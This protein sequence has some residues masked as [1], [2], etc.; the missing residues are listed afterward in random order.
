MT[1]SQSARFAILCFVVGLSPVPAVAVAGFAIA[2]FGFAWGLTE[3]STLVQE[4]APEE[5]RG[6]IMSLWLVGFIGSRPIAAAVLGTTADVVSVRTAFVAAAALAAV[7]ALVCRPRM[8][9]GPA[10]VP[11]GM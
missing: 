6:R 7:T 4:R 11:S 8:L 5:L 1:T 2:G 10:L 9:V 3:L